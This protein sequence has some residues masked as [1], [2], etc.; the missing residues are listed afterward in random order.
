MKKRRLALLLM[1]TIGALTIFSGCGSKSDSSTENNEVVAEEGEI[2]EE[3][4]SFGANVVKENPL[5][6]EEQQKWDALNTDCSKVNWKAVYS[7][8]NVDGIVI[9]E[10]YFDSMESGKKHL[11]VAYTNLT[12]AAVKMSFEGYAEDVKGNVVADLVESDVEI[13]PDNTLVREY[14]CDF[15]ELSGEINWKSFADEPSDKE[16]VP[17]EY[18][19]ELELNSDYSIKATRITDDVL[20]SDTEHAYGCVIDEE[21]NIL[22][23]GVDKFGVNVV[24]FIGVDSF[25]GKNADA[26]YFPNLYLYK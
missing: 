24:E 7:A 1:A 22:A 23:G 2:E 16:Y 8:P 15:E 25:D 11:V 14:T 5:T 13:G 9:S 20:V 3:A 21:G 4:P 12:G 6:S 10:T 18:N 19:V 17:I 26:L